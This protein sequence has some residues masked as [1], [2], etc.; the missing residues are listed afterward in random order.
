MKNIVNYL[1]ELGVMKRRTISG[2]DQF[3]HHTTNTIASH[4]YRAS[5]IGMIL[6]D[7]EGCKSSKSRFNAYSTR[8]R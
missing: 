1:H 2:F 6:A 3:A 5:I 4:A 7:M 8:K